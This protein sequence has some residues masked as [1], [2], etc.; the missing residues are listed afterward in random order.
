MSATPWPVSMGVLEAALRVVLA[1]SG[2]VS[3]LP[4]PVRRS[5]ILH[6]QIGA[7]LTPHTTYPNAT[8]LATVP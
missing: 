2:A 5:A 6:P 1:V 7:H 8:V 3:R 4:G